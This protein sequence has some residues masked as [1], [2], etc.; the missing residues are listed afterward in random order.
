M[1]S[2]TAKVTST[3]DSLFGDSDDEVVLPSNKTSPSSKKQPSNKSAPKKSSLFDDSESEDD[4]FSGMSKAK[5]A[6]PANAKTSAEVSFVTFDSGNSSM[7]SQEYCFTVQNKTSTH[8]KS[9]GEKKAKEPATKTNNSIQKS[10]LE[11]N[12]IFL[13]YDRRLL[14]MT[15]ILAVKLYLIANCK[16]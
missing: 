13:H 16:A 10:K 14:M 4:L 15:T 7:V 3:V 12:L 9:L 8:K 2:K 6:A 5:L 11:L 1:S